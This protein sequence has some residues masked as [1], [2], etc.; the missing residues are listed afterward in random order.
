MRISNRQTSIVGT[1][2]N[3]TFPATVLVVDPSMLFKT[4]SSGC[5]CVGT[6][7]VTVKLIKHKILK[8]DRND[9]IAK[10]RIAI[11]NYVFLTFI[12]RN[13]NF[14]NKKK[15]RFWLFLKLWKLSIR[16]QNKIILQTFF[17]TFLWLIK[18][19]NI[20]MTEIVCCHCPWHQF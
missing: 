4:L 2:L 15:K 16:L 20:K 7:S 11:I 12:I 8:L 13:S 14:I 3:V 5:M 10:I 1:L 6:S 17:V 18:Q 19:N 9:F